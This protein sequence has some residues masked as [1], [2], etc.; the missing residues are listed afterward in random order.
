M[1]KAFFW[2]KKW[3]LYAYGGIIFLLISLYSQVQMSVM[4]NE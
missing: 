3:A 4:I 2:N 1:I